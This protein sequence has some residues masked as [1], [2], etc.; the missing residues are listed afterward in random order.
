MATVT[1]TFIEDNTASYRATWTITVT[2]TDQTVASDFKVTMPTLKAKY[3]YSSGKTEGYVT[4]D[5]RLYVNG[6]SAGK[7]NY[8]KP[9]WSKMS[10]G[11]TYAISSSSDTR[12]TVALSSIFNVSN[13][14]TRTVNVTASNSSV[15]L[16]TENA[17]GDYYNTY[18]SS[19]VNYGA[20]ATVT[21]NAPP[22]ATVSALSVD[23]APYVYAGATTASVTVSD[24][25]AYYGGDIDSV[26]LTIGNQSDSIPGN[27][28]LSIA[29]DTAGT[30]TPTVT[31]TDSR[32]Q[33]KSYSLDPITVN[34]YTAPSVSFDV[35]RTN[36]SG[37]LDDEGT[38]CLITATLTFA[39]VIASALAPSV[40]AT[41]E[42]GTQTT[43]T[44][45]WYTDNTL[46]TA[47]TWANVSSGDVVYGIFSGVNTQ[48]SYQVSVRPRDSEGTGEAIVQTLSS[49]FYTVDFLAGGHGIAFGQPSSEAGFFCKMDANFMNDVLID[50]PDYQ[51]TGTTDK[52]I[53]DAVVALGWDSDVIV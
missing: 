29:L 21:L 2:G 52:A 49:A 17:Y 18:S 32:G 12:T 25:T 24:A 44:V 35:D 5:L 8:S 48:Y 33:T 50:L 14:D 36:S 9:A 19:S 51:T 15:S 45:N 39:D 3:V 26:T 16:G 4:A 20:L 23:T 37:Q 43:P 27:G 47:V 11:T 38:Y 22:I 7:V 30:F 46:T 31:V 42:N 28:T 40:V 1:K 53:Y 41:D 34:S 13:K 6:V 10:S